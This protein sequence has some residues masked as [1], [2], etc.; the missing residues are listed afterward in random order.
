MGAPL[1]E[2]IHARPLTGSVRRGVCQGH[3]D[4]FSVDPPEAGRHWLF[5]MSPK[6]GKQTLP[7]RHVHLEVCL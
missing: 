6:T 2:T 4:I 3:E 7:V 1:V 5:G